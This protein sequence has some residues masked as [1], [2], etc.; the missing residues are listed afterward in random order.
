[1]YRKL[2]RTKAFV[3]DSTKVKFNDQQYSRFIIFIGKL[4][5]Q[6]PMPAEAKDHAL[7]RQWQGFREFH[8]SGDLL[9]IYQIIDNTVRLV[10]IGSHSQLF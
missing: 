8:V 9:V 4:L 10:R 2:E 1:M 6:N 3:K 7:K 5:S